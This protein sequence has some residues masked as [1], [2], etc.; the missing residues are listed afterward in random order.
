M[1]SPIRATLITVDQA[2]AMLKDQR[3]QRGE[4]FPQ[5]ALSGQYI[6][7]DYRLTRKREAFKIRRHT[8]LKK[9]FR[10]YVAFDSDNGQTL[11]IHNFPSLSEACFWLNTG[12]KP[13]DTDSTSSYQEWKTHH[14]E[15]IE[16]LKEQLRT[17]HHD[18]KKVVATPKKPSVSTV[19][20]TKHLKK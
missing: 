6:L 10:S 18:K 14:V 7:P 13:T 15:E 8:F 5:L 19:K 20:K 16:R 4:R 3:D 2:R 12:L 17:Q 11:W 1:E 9:H